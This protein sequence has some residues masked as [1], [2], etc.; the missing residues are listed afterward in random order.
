MTQAS[1]A[2][3]LSLRHL[4][5]VAVILAEGNLMRAAT[6]LNMTQSAVTK[7][8]QDAEAQMGV[9]LFLRTNRGVVATAFGA[10][11]AAH[12]RLIL[13]QVGRAE[14]EMADL[15][16]GTAGQV[17]IGTL[18]AGSAGLLPEAIMRLRQRQPNLEIRVEEATNDVLMPA[19]R[20]GEL[21]LVLGRLPEFRDR[22]GL[23]QE[24]LMDDFARIV[25]RR[26]HP[27]ALRTDLQLADLLT[28]DW[29]LPGH[30]TTLRRQIETAFRDANLE[31]PVHSVE[32]VSFLTTRQLLRQTDY[33]A[34]WPAQLA[35]LESRE[36]DIVALHIPLPS[37]RRPIGISTR[38]DDLMSPAATRLVDSLRQVARQTAPPPGPA[39]HG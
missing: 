38:A 5:I 9:P 32:T 36:G 35:A 29:I 23:R 22:D 11:L 33:L 39:M 17:T 7:A 28:C 25:A 16:D 34:V 19:L 1:S 8:L 24:H 27:L 30:T 10:K 31:P 15:R 12:A 14:Q 20:S 18:L 21:D 3:R 26:N 4:R 2:H 37:T 6:A 13:A